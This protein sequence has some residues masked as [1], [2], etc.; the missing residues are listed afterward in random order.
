MG[1]TVHGGKHANTLCEKT[2]QD[3]V[4]KAS[5]IKIKKQLSALDIACMNS[6]EL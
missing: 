5:L 1:I 4:C 6:S 2:L 3:I